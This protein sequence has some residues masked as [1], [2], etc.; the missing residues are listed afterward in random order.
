M[1]DWQPTSILGAIPIGQSS[2]LRG[3]GGMKLKSIKVF[4]V[5]V[6]VAA[7]LW[8][9]H[10]AVAYDIIVTPGYGIE[11]IFAPALQFPENIAVSPSGVIVVFEHCTED[12]GHRIVRV[13]EDGTL[14]TYGDVI[15][16][17][18]RAIAFDATSNLYTVDHDGALYKITPEGETSRK[19]PRRPRDP[20]LYE[21]RTRENHNPSPA[22]R[23]LMSSGSVLHRERQSRRA[24]ERF[25]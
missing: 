12:T 14:S 11:R 3:C 6:F 15:S 16:K 18:Y 7:M 5:S 17:C 19:A 24:R 1:K 13:H 22:R 10:Q 8:M 21:M 2:E 9:V 23:S 4:L 20:T 25:L